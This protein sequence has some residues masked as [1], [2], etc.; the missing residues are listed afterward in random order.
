MFYD[1]VERVLYSGLVALGGVVFGICIGGLIGTR[2]ERD[3]CLA[4]LCLIHSKFRLRSKGDALLNVVTDDIAK[5]TKARAFSARLQKMQSAKG[6][7]P[8]EGHETSE[9]EVILTED[10]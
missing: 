2:H 10:K 5:G 1:L 3:R 9:D 4:L 6:G 8:H 7:L